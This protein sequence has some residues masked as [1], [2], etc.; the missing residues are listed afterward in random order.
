MDAL[1]YHYGF[2]DLGLIL[3][4]AVRYGLGD[5][6]VLFVEAPDFVDVTLRAQA[7]RRLVHLINFPVAKPLSTG[8]RH[9]GRTMVPLHEIVVGYRLAPGE[10]VREAR[11]ASNEQ[12]LAVTL[13]DGRACVSVPRLDDHEIV[14][15]ELV[16]EAA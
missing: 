13:R 5:A 3:A 10:Q 15:F 14:I 6:D 16:E 12:T 4:N 11:L 9:P 8:W 7:S 2:P 1:F